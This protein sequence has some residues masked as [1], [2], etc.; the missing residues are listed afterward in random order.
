MLEYDYTRYVP[1]HR[2]PGWWRL[3]VSIGAGSLMGVGKEKAQQGSAGYLCVGK[4]T[5]GENIKP[6]CYSWRKCK[7][8]KQVVDWKGLSGK[9]WAGR[10]NLIPLSSSLGFE[11]GKPGGNHRHWAGFTGLPRCVACQAS[12]CTAGFLGG[13]VTLLCCSA[14]PYYVDFY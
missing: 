6:R 11:T 3:E 14:Y 10:C 12:L 2:L 5:W 1:Q 4:K 9:F 8:N 7:C 13:G